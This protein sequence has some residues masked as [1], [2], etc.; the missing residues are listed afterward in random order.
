MLLCCSICL[1]S[2]KGTGDTDLQDMTLHWGAQS[3]S[4]HYGTSCIFIATSPGVLGEN[5]LYVLS[6]SKAKDHVVLTW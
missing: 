1:Q 3:V 5:S 2:Y 4:S 6:F